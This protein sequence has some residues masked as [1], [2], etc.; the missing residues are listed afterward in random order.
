ML[1]SELVKNKAIASLLKVGRRNRRMKNAKKWRSEVTRNFE[2]TNKAIEKDSSRSCVPRSRRRT[3][4]YERDRVKLSSARGRPSVT[5]ICSTGSDQK[6]NVGYKKKSVLHLKLRN[7]FDGSGPNDLYLD[8]FEILE[9]GFRFHFGIFVT[10]ERLAGVVGNVVGTQVP[11]ARSIFFVVIMIAFT[12]VVNFLVVAFR[13]VRTGRLL[14]RGDQD[15]GRLPSLGDGRLKHFI[16]RPL[17]ALLLRRALRPEGGR[18]TFQPAGRRR[19][20][21]G[22]RGTVLL[23]RNVYRIILTVIGETQSSTNLL[24]KIGRPLRGVCGGVRRGRNVAE[25]GIMFAALSV[26]G[27]IEKHHIAT[28][29]LPFKGF[30][31][32]IS[33]VALQNLLLELR[34]PIGDQV[35]LSSYLQVLQVGQRSHG[36]VGNERTGGRNQGQIDRS[37]FE[38]R[39]V[40]SALVLGRQ[41]IADV[42]IAHIWIALVQGRHIGHLTLASS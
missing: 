14:L 21:S 17:H 31:R 9:E 29:P 22:R 7:E 10:R 18:M 37:A 35:L 4:G 24:E 5:I 11:A 25:G 41:R 19:S 6:K 32:R 27:V 3:P 26:D 28:F 2:S 34:G 23:G 40:R 12:L 1:E 38:R 36:K 16:L 42:R 20:F 8:L 15:D 13:F 39:L 33:D 30:F